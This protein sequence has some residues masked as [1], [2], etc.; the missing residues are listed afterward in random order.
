MKHRNPA[1]FAVAAIAL[2]LVVPLFTLPCA[3][4][5]AESD[6]SLVLARFQVDDDEIKPGDDDQPTIA[7]RRRGPVTTIAT[8]GDAPQSGYERDDESPTVT[9]F[10][11]LRTW[12]EAVRGF[13][14]RRDTLR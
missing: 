10:G 12:L 6:L 9:P 11:V 5:E 14:E 13:I 8:P 4:S 1:P 3:A 7:G 2:A